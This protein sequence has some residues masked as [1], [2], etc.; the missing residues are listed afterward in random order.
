MSGSTARIATLLSSGSLG[1]GERVS[2]SAASGQVSAAFALPGVGEVLANAYRRISSWPAADGGEFFT[3]R[4]LS[5][6][7]LDMDPKAEAA[8][9]AWYDASHV[10]NLLCVPGYR[11][12]ARF[13]LLD[14]MSRDLST[15]PRYLALYEL[16]S[17]EVVVSIGPDPARQ[18]PEAREELDIFRRDW[19]RFTAKVSWNIFRPAG[20]ALQAARP[21]AVAVVNAGPD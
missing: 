2:H 4:P 13:R 17:E 18:G 20:V 8:M 7:T 15:G 16:E 21:G 5:V 3:G 12:A 10:P 9:N 19:A 11:N 14:E 6:I 1:T